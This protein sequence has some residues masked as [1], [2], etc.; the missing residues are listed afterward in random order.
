M[1][2]LAASLDPGL[3]R[4]RPLQPV[5]E[6]WPVR[7]LLPATLRNANR[8]RMAPKPELDRLGTMLGDVRTVRERLPG[9]ACPGAPAM[10]GQTLLPAPHRGMPP[11][12]TSG[13]PLSV[14]AFWPLQV[15][16]LPIFAHLAW[17]MLRHRSLTLP[18]AGRSAS[19][20]PAPSVV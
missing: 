7:I 9:S 10:T 18:T 19:L 13:P 4:I 15:F 14:S 2:L 3:E 8:E 1:V 20:S 12:D 5:G 16:D 11:P 6:W 17:L